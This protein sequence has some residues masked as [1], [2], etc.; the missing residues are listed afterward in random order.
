MAM[1][2][3]QLKQQLEVSKY[4]AMNERERFGQIHD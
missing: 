2:T 4:E 3:T 1:F